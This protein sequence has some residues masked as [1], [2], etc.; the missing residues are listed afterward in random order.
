MQQ[1]LAKGLRDLSYGRFINSPITTTE[2]FIMKLLYTSL[3]LLP[4]LA[5]CASVVEGRSQQIQVNTSP[6]GAT[7]TLSREGF[8]IGSI[9]PTPGT[10]YVEKTKHDIMIGCEKKGYENATYFNKSGAAGATFGNIILGGLVGWGI[11]SATG[12]DNKY[13]SPVNLSLS[14]R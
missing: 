14:K 2:E 8:P 7:C 5:S 11:D 6:P 1:A 12:S 10:I 3:M 4:M 9:S 13:D